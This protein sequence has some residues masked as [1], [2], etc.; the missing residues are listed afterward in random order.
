[1]SYQ[2]SDKELQPSNVFLYNFPLHIITFLK[3][4]SWKTN[5]IF[6]PQRKTVYR[7]S[8]SITL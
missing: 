5:A 2:S 6:F 8:K 7:N 4:L 3:L 1:M